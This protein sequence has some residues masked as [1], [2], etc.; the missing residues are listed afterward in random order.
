MLDPIQGLWIGQALG[1]MEQCSIRSFVRNGHPYHLFVYDTVDG[2]PPGTAIMDAAQILPKA[3]LF[4]N[5]PNT[6]AAVSDLFRYKL[7]YERGG[8]WADLDVVCLRP[9][10]FTQEYVFTQELEKDGTIGF[11]SCVIKTS[12]GSE[13]MRAC[14]EVCLARGSRDV[15]WGEF[16]PALLGKAITQLE[17]TKHLVPY[18][19]FCPI[20]YWTWDL[21][22]RDDQEAQE[23]IRGRI[24]GDTRAIHLWNQMWRLGGADKARSWPRD[25]L[26]EK[27]KRRYESEEDET[28]PL[29]GD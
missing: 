21:L 18:R 5:D 28:A 3:L 8:Y 22:L 16:G 1:P 19:V 9:F 23:A 27:L 17:L 14:L 29:D 20:P 15:R 11:G 10:S 25:C 2:I 26:Y 24:G 13:S 7:L 4:A 12:A 6:F